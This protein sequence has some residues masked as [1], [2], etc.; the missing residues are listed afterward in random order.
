M[1]LRAKR[2]PVGIHILVLRRVCVLAIWDDV[3]DIWESP[4]K[5]IEFE[6]KWRKAGRKARKEVWEMLCAE[7]E[8]SNGQE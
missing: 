7:L 1:E 5:W 2:W 6:G 8:E 3:V 4:V